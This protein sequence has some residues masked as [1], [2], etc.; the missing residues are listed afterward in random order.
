MLR[1]KIWASIAGC[2]ALGGVVSAQDGAPKPASLGK[3]QP[4][5]GYTARGASP[6]YPLYTPP[7]TTKSYA[8]TGNIRTTAFASEGETPKVLEIPK[9][10]PMMMPSGMGMGP[11]VIAPP[12]PDP[13][14]KLP[15]PMIVGS[16][17]NNPIIS[18]MTPAPFL[19][20]NGVPMGYGPMN[21]GPNLA[22]APCCD[23]PC[24]W[25]A[26]EYLNWRTA[27]VKLP[28]MVTTA[29][30]G[31]QGVLG[32][33]NTSVLYGNQDVM[34][35]WRSGLRVRGGGWFDKATGCGVDL[36]FFYL[37]GTRDGF[38][39]ESNGDPGLFR[40]FTNTDGTQNAQ[41]VGFIAPD[42]TPILAGRV[43][44][45]NSTELLGADANFRQVLNCENGNHLDFVM[46][47]RFMR[48]RDTLS[49]REDL[50][51][52]DPQELAAPLGTRITVFDRF[53]TIN[54]FH[55]GQIG[56]A[57]EWKS[58]NFF[59]N[60]RGT[61]ALGVTHIRTKI[62]GSTSVITPTGE[63]SFSQGG[64]LA[65]PTNIGG[66][67]SYNFSV[68][69]EV[70]LSVGYEISKNV[71][72]FGGYNYL[73]WSNVARAGEQVDS[74][75]NSTFIPNPDGDAPS[76]LKRPSFDRKTSNF[77][78]HGWSIGLEFRW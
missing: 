72:V 44:V 32:D 78:A 76:G 43:T 73:Y 36:G 69:P 6:S 16:G 59:V 18:S 66:Y 10:P 55:G 42:G 41:L 20:A 22:C 2:L 54:Q 37:G 12:V 48:L 13:K 70:G 63:S 67:S 58:G 33:P 11:A 3:P 34:D 51:A 64:L 35:N 31:S 40:P 50:R 1:R 7:P 74:V 4:V 39:A 38:S 29:P 26:P 27:G 68:I 57:G 62:D 23:L 25:I 56:I 28:A 46:G 75:V 52:T 9:G 24:A 60:Y 8:P 30:A 45:S 15:P 19:D 71:R 49:V 65:L 5:A 21:C 53:E 14:D 61:V 17:T 47:Y 77:W